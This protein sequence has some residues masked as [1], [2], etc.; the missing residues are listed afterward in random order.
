MI[1]KSRTRRT[2]VSD[3]YFTPDDGD[4]YSR[5]DQVS[6]V[7]A[8]RDEKFNLVYPDDRVFLFVDCNPAVG[9]ITPYRQPAFM[10]IRP[11]YGTIC[12]LLD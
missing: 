12:G 8:W 2:L 1:V 7:A 11:A 9:T 4:D 10:S 6:N 5:R 3:S